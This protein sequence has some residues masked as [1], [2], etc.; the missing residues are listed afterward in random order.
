MVV[1]KTSTRSK[2]TRTTAKRSTTAK[3]GSIRTA[4]KSTRGL[5]Y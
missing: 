2:T 1:K 4:R 5:S 3:R